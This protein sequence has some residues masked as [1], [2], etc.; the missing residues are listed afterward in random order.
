M[1]CFFMVQF[2]SVG[3]LLS[4]GWPMSTEMSQIWFSEV[5]CLQRALDL[6]FCL[7][8]CTWSLQR[9]ATAVDVNWG[10]NGLTPRPTGCVE[11]EDAE[12]LSEGRR[13]SP[14]EERGSR[15]APAGAVWVLTRQCMHP[16]MQMGGHGP[17]EK[18]N[19]MWR[20]KRSLPLLSRPLSQSFLPPFTSIPKS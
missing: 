11:E 20:W 16:S 4:H 14:M 17:K 12:C 2:P 8:Q 19:C 3:S 13:S 15:P 5:S 18:R 1:K 10:T 9:R 6:R 7:S